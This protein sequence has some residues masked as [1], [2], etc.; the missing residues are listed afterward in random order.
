MTDTQN[1]EGNKQTSTKTVT[2]G[3]KLPNGLIC[4]LGKFGDEDYKAVTLKGSNSAVVHG[5]YGLTEGVD[6]S[7]WNAWKKKHNN[8]SFV[9][10]GLVFAVGD[11]ASARDHAIDLSALK[12]GLE[13]L[14]PLKKVTGP[15]GELLLEVDSSHFAQAKRDVAQATQRRG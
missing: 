15:N 4:E 3:C 10:K 13:P 6:E 1:S 7:F 8:L 9:K 11:I 12:T 5:G 14:D 2:V